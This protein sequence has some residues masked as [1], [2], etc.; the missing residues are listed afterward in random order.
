MILENH[1]K[2]RSK[3]M[4]ENS[5]HTHECRSHRVFG[6]SDAA[7][8][9]CLLTPSVSCAELASVRRCESETGVM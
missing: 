5:A 1:S 2:I 4:R 6:M 8:S 9:Q 7:L 3:L